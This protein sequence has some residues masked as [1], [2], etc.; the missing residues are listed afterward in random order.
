MSDPLSEAR[1]DLRKAMDAMAHRWG[2]GATS[3]LMLMHL[4]PILARLDALPAPIRCVDSTEL[5]GTPAGW[6]YPDT[7]AS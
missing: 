5:G 3:D 2:I 4:Q 6:H 7:S 1:D